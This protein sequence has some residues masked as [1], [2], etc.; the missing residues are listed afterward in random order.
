M[1]LQASCHCGAVRFS[2]ESTAPY[3]FMHCYCSIC[4]KTNGAAGAAVNL[5]ADADTL[6]VEGEAHIRVYRAWLDHPRRSER[7]VGERRFC[8]HCG[9]GLWVWDPR[10]PALIH[11]FASAVDTPL[12][13]PPQR[14]HILLDSAPDWVNVPAS[15]A[16]QV[17]EHY[18]DESLMQWHERNKLVTD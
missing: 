8:E 7:S 12:P 18:P 17:F 14:S 5:H 9:S 4:R 10:W 15:G 3:P 1:L 6:K 13:T 11:P 2:C 16:D